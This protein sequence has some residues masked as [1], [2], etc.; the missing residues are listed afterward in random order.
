MTLWELGNLRR[1]AARHGIGVS[2]LCILATVRLHSHATMRMLAERCGI[3]CAAVT[4]AVDRL[5]ADGLVE[6]IAAD[7]DKRCLLVRPTEKGSTLL[8][9]VLGWLT[10]AADTRERAR[11][12]AVRARNPQP[13][14][15]TEIRHAA[16][17]GKGEV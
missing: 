10:D 15:N 5:E 7:F 2:Q 4:G 1:E 13:F 11:E 16:R 9:G 14:A 17:A 12:S 6:R 3:S 8:R